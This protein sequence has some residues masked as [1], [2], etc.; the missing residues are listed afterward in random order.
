MPS[1]Y[2]YIPNL[3]GYVRIV[4]ALL[5]CYT[6][7]KDP[8]FSAVLYSISQIGDLFDGMAARK[9]KQSTTF[10]SVLDMVIPHKYVGD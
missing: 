10:G 9:F 6:G 3:I 1:V 8:V 7:D 4:C 2:L 5:F